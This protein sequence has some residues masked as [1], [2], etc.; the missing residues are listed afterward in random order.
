M[1]KA[2]IATLDEILTGKVPLKGWLYLDR[3]SWSLNTEG[4]MIEEDIDA[5]PNLPFPPEVIKKLNLTEVLDAACIEDIIDNINAQTLN[6]T[7][8]QTFS[9]FLFYFENDAFIEF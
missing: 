8:E 9:A 2:I 4:I 7:A 3:K 5:D 1:H 6:P